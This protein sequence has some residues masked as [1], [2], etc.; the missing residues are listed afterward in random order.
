MLISLE[1]V[2]GRLNRF[3]WVEDVKESLSL[4]QITHDR[5]NDVERRF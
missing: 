4:V 1:C 2:H 5:G 3:E